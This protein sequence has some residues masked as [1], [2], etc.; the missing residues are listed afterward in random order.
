MLQKTAP[1]GLSAAKLIDPNRRFRKQ[2][3]EPYAARWLSVEH[4]KESTKG[5]ETYDP[6]S[7]Y[8]TLELNFAPFVLRP[9]AAV[10]A[11]VAL[12]TWYVVHIDPSLREHMDLSMDAHVVLGSALSFLVVFRTN[13]SY[14]RWWEARVLWEDVIGT[15]SSHATS[16]ASAL[17]TDEA[18]EE[19]FALLIAFVVSLK[20]MLRGKKVQKDEIGERLNWKLVRELNAAANPPLLCMH[21][22]GRVV[23][24][25]LPVDDPNTETDESAVH[26]AIFISNGEIIRRLVADVYACDRIKGTPMTY[27]YVATLRTFLISAFCP[28]SHCLLNLPAPA[29]VPDICA[30]DPDTDT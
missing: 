19:C 17:R 2:R 5:F 10:T 26:A 25:N 16:V 29:P 14:G 9:W 12:M 1:N 4:F 13:S 15:C 6:E 21:K 11:L 27:G 22:L 8:Q 23:R 30:S 28:R 20:A 18:T 7:W 3:R 24:A